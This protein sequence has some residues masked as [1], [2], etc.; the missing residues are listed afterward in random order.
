MG[1]FRC[2][3]D[4]AGKP[5]SEEDGSIEDE[6][7]GHH[8]HTAEHQPPILELLA[9]V[10]AVERRIFVGH[11]QVVPEHANRVAEVLLDRHHVDL[12]PLTDDERHDHCEMR[13]RNERE[14]DAAHPV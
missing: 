7:G 4:L 10:V 9:V 11:P 3:D 1:D 8:H 13:R 6:P 12:H 5:A 14:E 2:G